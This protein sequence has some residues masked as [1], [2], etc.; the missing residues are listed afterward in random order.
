MGPKSSLSGPRGGGPEGGPKEDPKGL[1][2]VGPKEGGPKGEPRGGLKGRPKED[3]MV[4]A[5]QGTTEAKTEAKAEAKTA[6]LEPTG[7]QPVRPEKMASSRASGT[8]SLRPPP[9]EP[10]DAAAGWSWPGFA[11]AIP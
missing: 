5:M 2:Q 10:G 4:E 9:T 8:S 1:S 6:E 7:L 3:A 11:S